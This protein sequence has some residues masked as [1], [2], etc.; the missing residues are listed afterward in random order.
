MSPESSEQHTSG[1]FSDSHVTEACTA[2]EN[3]PVH[4][5][6]VNVFRLRVTVVDG[7][8]RIQNGAADAQAAKRTVNKRV[9]LSILT[10]RPKCGNE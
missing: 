1:P 4:V 6:T 5:S 8:F 10:D 3:T 9:I 2:V 7:V